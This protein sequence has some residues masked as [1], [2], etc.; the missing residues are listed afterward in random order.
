MALP[1]QRLVD[2]GSRDVRLAWDGRCYTKEE[3]VDWYGVDSGIALWNDAGADTVVISFK[4]MS[5]DTACQDM[6]TR[7]ALGT[8]ARNVRDH[9]R[10]YSSEDGIRKLDYDSDLLISGK[11]LFQ[12]LGDTRSKEKQGC[13]EVLALEEAKAMLAATPSCLLV[14]VIRKP[15]WE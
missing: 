15:L 14:N 2:L 7:R 13:I 5:G 6:V 10:K 11:L 8:T 9:L 3:F 12:G 4:L 1:C